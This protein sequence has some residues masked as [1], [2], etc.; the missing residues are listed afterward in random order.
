[1]SKTNK[2]NTISYQNA[3]GPVVIPMTNDYLFK[4]MLQSNR[5]A[6]TGLIAALLHEEPRNIK[7]VHVEN[8]IILGETVDEKTVILDL[9]VTFNNGMRI[10]LELQVVNQDN[11]TERSTYYACRNF[12]TLNKG[13]DYSKVKPLYQIGILDFS[14]FPDHPSF[15]STYQLRDSRN[16]WLYTDKLTIGVLDLTNIALAGSIDRRY[17]INEWAALFKAKTWEEIKMVA[18][19]NKAIGEAAKTIYT[20]SEDE[21]IRLQCEAREDYFKQKRDSARRNRELIKELK[22]KDKEIEGKDKALEE[23]DK[24]LEEKNKALEEKNKALAEK[25]AI[26]AE[27][28]ARLKSGQV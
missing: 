28:E 26:I 3:T 5:V 16:H 7:R 17:N 4:A 8:P 24:A 11:W 2:S 23:K 15:Y 13:R 12:A 1:M 10:N 22:V 18:G 19:K 20:L 21:R 9:N 25:D 6:L 14:I 27:L